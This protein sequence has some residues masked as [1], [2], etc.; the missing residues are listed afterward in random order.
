VKKE[1]RMAE[2]PRD[3]ISQV[4]VNSG[5]DPKRC[6]DQNLLTMLNEFVGHNKLDSGDQ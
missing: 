6:R 3:G 2:Q 1:R 4:L 5:V